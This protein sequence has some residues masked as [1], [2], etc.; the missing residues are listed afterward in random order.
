MGRESIAEKFREKK[1]GKKI[2]KEV[3]IRGRYLVTSEDF[4][5]D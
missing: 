4:R 1:A 5:E 3:D 2:I